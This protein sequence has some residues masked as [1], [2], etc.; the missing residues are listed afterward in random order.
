MAAHVVPDVTSVVTDDA[1]KNSVDS[2]L[3]TNIHLKND[4][5]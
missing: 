4:T 1:S 5:S 3:K 2:Y